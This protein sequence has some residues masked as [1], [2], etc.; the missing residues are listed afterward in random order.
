MDGKDGRAPGP[1]VFAVCPVLR[2]KTY[3]RCVHPR[4]SAVLVGAVAFEPN[5]LDGYWLK[6]HLESR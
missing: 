1:A 5:A 4:G 6:A 3:P 2:G